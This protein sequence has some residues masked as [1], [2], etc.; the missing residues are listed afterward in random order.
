M[1]ALG[2]YG[3]VEEDLVP[4]QQNLLFPV[5]GA[6]FLLV[7]GGIELLVEFKSLLLVKISVVAS[8]VSSENDN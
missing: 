1:E 3:S 2:K 5:F 8:S 6:D 4:K 7:L